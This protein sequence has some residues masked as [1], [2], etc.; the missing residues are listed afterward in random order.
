[1]KKQKSVHLGL[2][3]ILLENWD[4]SQKQ[5]SDHII[6]S[7][8]KYS[9]FDFASTKY[10]T[11]EKNN[12]KHAR[13]DSTIALNSKEGSKTFLIQETSFVSSLRRSGHCV[14]AISN[15]HICYT[16]CYLFKPA[17]I[18]LDGISE[19][20]SNIELLWSINIHST[21]RKIAV[22]AQKLCTF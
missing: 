15:C 4:S 9:A 21:V 8:K 18:N 6:L 1:M 13:I 3:S 2:W 17:K 12:Q 7:S 16:S 20:K 11:E 10:S 22:Y 19:G 5:N 14:P